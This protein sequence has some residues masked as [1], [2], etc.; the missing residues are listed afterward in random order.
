MPR[1]HTRVVA[2]GQEDAANGPDEGGV[3]GA[4]Q[5]RAANRAREQRVANEKIEA[6]LPAARHFETDAAG[7][8]ARR[9][10]RT[11]LEVAEGDGV[12]RRIETVDRRRRRIHLQ[13]EEPALFDGAIVDEE[14]VA[15]QPHR[16]VQSPYGGADTRDVIHVGMG[17][18]DVRDRESFLRDELEQSIDLVAR[19]DDHTF[20]RA[21]TG[22]DEA[23]LVERGDGLR[24]DYDHAVILAILDD[25]LFTSKIR[26][27]AAHAGVTVSFARSAQ[28]ALEQMHV[29]PPSLVILDL[30]NPR[31]DPLGILAAMKSEPLLAA[32]PTVG[33]VA[34]VDGATI[35]A[36]RAA[37]VD[38]VLARSAFA[39]TLADILGRA[40]R[41]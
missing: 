6:P 31:T 37:G 40:A 21:G 15:V 18:Q 3:V 10:V 1:V 24:L 23:V 5:I 17:K 13:A 14:I 29:T 4:G 20:T 27:T 33:Y 34:H 12:V 11:R 35:A 39:G 36:A 32:V 41:Q 7:A 8:V 25:L 16:H 2:E 22:D 38:D 19:V 26:T 9:V 28:T 30:N